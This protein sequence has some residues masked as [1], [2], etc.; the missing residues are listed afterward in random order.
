[1]A[2]ELHNA[3]LAFVGTIRNARTAQAYA[4]ALSA[5]EQVAPSDLACLDESYLM[6]FMETMSGYSIATKQLRLGAVIS[7]FAHLI[8]TQQKTAVSLDRARLIRQK[9]IG[10][11]PKRISNYSMA[12]LQA[13]IDYARG[14]TGDT[15]DSWGRDRRCCFRDRALIITLA[16][17]GLRKSEAISLKLCDVDMRAGQS[18][19]VGKGDKQAVV[20]FG[21]NSLQAIR[22]Y[23]EARDDK[24]PNSPL[25][26]AEG[27]G[28]RRRESD[29]LEPSTV[30][31]IVTRRARE[32][33]GH[34]LPVHALRH[35]FVTRTWQVTG[36]LFLTKELARHASTETTTRYIHAA[37]GT[38]RAAHARVFNKQEISREAKQ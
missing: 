1:M 6:P 29:H 11:N 2:S 8:Y 14:L 9:L 22:E 16:E 4:R 23:V 24:D 26:M 7:F 18:V 25:F 10:R 17:T 15:R 21:P 27:R 30:N 33:L 37:N 5:F 32:C 12:D 19:V 34:S 20:Y 28:G 3:T 35:Y 36:D 38:L 13:L 31:R